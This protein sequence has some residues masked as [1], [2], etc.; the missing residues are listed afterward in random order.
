MNN[1]ILLL[2][3]YLFVLLEEIYLALDIEKVAADRMI[4]YCLMRFMS[5]TREYLIEENK[6]LL[7]NN[8][9]NNK[10]IDEI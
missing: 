4:I 8:E 9:L 1:K 10:S 6:L 3:C 7:T 5:V 2:K